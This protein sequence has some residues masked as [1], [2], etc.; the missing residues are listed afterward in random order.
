MEPALGISDVS[1][2]SDVAG[3]QLTLARG[4]AQLCVEQNTSK[5]LLSIY[6][7]QIVKA[8]ACFSFSLG[9]EDGM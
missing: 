8:S 5:R 3:A 4:A 1:G 7:K 9:H 2:R 6:N